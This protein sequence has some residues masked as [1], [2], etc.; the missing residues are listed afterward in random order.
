MVQWKIAWRELRHHPGRATLTV[1]SV[2]IGVAG[3]LAAGL[4][5]G[6]ARRAY[7]E[8]YQATTG[9]AALEVT[10]PGGG[11]LE[12]SL[13]DI[14]R[15][16]PGV[17][18][19]VPLIERPVILYYQGGRMK[20]I[21]LGIDA[22]LDAAVRDYQLVEGRLFSPG[23]PE[24]SETRSSST[25]PR[26]SSWG[27][28]ESQGGVL[29]DENLARGLKLRV[30]DELKMLVRRGVVRTSVWGL[31]RP[32]SGAAAI[33]SGAVFMPLAW[34]QR[35][36]AAAGQIDRIQLVLADEADAAEVQSALRKR[37]PSTVHVQPPATRSRL[38]EETILSLENGLR[39][40]TVFSL[41]AAVFIITN[42]FFMSVGQ[43]RRQFAV[44]RAIGATK[45]QTSGLL[46]REA[47]LMASLG[48]AAGMLL[49]WA[50]ALLLN[51]A[52]GNLF[53]TPMPSI[54]VKPLQAALA[55]AVG[56][57][58][59]LFGA[60]VPARRI[61]RF[62]PLEG[63]SGIEHQDVEG[64]SWWGILS[65]AGL[66]LSALLLL[67]GCYA[68]WLPAEAS[69]VGTV[70]A[71]VGLVLLLPLVLRPLTY[72]AEMLLRPVVGIESRLA[73]RQLL[74]HRGRTTLT[75]GVLFVMVGTGLGLANAIVDSVE[76]VRHWYRTALVTD[77]FVRAAMPS[78]ETGL[79]AAVPEDVGKEI[80]GLKGVA[81]IDSVRLVAGTAAKE[82][83]V[84]I[85]I[86]NEFCADTE[87]GRSSS[88]FSAPPDDGVVIGSVL[89]QRT[90]LKAGDAL[91]LDTRY[92]PRRLRVSEVVNNYMAGGLT[93]RMS[94]ELAE[95]LLGLE[96]VDAYVVK[97][98]RQ[99][100]KPVEASLRE[101][102]R[103]HGLLL[104]SYAELT[105]MIENMM[106]GLVSSLW[107]L[108]V[109]GL[110]VAAFGVMNTLG[111]NV[112]EQ[113]RE[114]GVLRV[115]A[116]TR[117]QVRKAILAQATMLGLLGLAPG[118]LAGPVMAYVINLATMPVT[119]HP[120]VFTL[121]LRLLLAGCSAA[122]AIVMIA[123]L[124]P[125]E[126]AA[127]LP[128]VTALRYE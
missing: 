75:M 64:H 34:A 123:A 17:K 10:G 55:V 80:R 65:G 100:R 11:P 76:D 97:V 63:M 126:R 40:A 87:E 77:F 49:G 102:C 4:S 62:S 36:F 69:V 9:R 114:L 47:L 25:K 61:A 93:V 21:A 82:S 41:L 50:G 96:G 20:A 14:V 71:F 127:R 105:Q 54:T 68:G 104:Q 81:R 107:G 3:V 12:T 101:L 117:G 84:V 120:V 58:V 24:N 98:D 43:R 31:V 1:L 78:M 111:M 30:G 73:R 39:M 7:E 18:A 42:T 90:G 122:L 27:K 57:G 51:G 125:A 86:G 121:H 5:T 109:L 99:Q 44:L 35:R 118:A 108:L 48:T 79:S 23:T 19:A 22:S 37:L 13:L 116:A 67:L 113:T 26:T 16:T 128:L 85:A 72:L 124:I 66:L 8:M 56:F 88:L 29:L 6:S 60:A 33:Q 15:E 28:G 89:A 83:V 46:F 45:Q 115:V 92:G 53:Q 119:G 103:R 59:C 95:E 106:G 110:I 112:L 70:L 32:R 91:T 38:A 52:L 2:V 94:R 74:R